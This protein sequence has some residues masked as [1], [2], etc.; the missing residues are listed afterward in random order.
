MKNRMYIYAMCDNSRSRWSLEIENLLCDVRYMCWFAACTHNKDSNKQNKDA[1]RLFYM[2]TPIGVITTVWV[3]EVL[4]REYVY[5]LYAHLVKLF[6]ISVILGNWLGL[7][8]RANCER[9]PWGL[10]AERSD[11]YFWHYFSSFFLS[12]THTFLPEGVFLGFWHFTS[13]PHF[14]KV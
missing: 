2:L 9:C 3:Y 11:H 13:G 4:P 7:I 10:K 5:M 6:K 1:F 8:S 12:G 14:K